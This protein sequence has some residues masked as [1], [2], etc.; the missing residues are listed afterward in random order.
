MQYVGRLWI[1]TITLSD[2]YTWR[3]KQDDPAVIL[4]KVQDF[5][6]DVQVL[7][8]P[9]FYALCPASSGAVCSSAPRWGTTHRRLQFGPLHGSPRGRFKTKPPPETNA[10]AACVTSAVRSNQ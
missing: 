2:L 8:R 7:A 9:A 10:V 1:S 5:L 6:R 3:Y 4:N